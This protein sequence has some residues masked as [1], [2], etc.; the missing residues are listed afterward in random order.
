MKIFAL[1]T[2]SLLFAIPDAQARR[3]HAMQAV[4][5]AAQNCPLAD[6]CGHLAGPSQFL[7]SGPESGAAGAKFG[8]A[9]RATRAAGAQ[10]V[11]H[12]AGCP[13]RAFCGCGAAVRVFGHSVRSLWLAAAWLRFPRA[14]PGSGMVAARRGHVFVLESHVSGSTWIVY[15]ANSGGGGTRI[16]AR[17][18]AGY[19]IVNPHA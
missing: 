6:G 13:A 19:S 10:M 3:H 14:A 4:P 16:H 5:Q 18:I 7:A 1:I 17:S 8:V 11:G 9:S 15:D 2:L 12:P